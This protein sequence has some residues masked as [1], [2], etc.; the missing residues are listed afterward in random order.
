M[1]V[2]GLAPSGGQ[3]VRGR[4]PPEA[5]EVFAAESAILG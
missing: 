3:G 4:S 2:G 1:G 5:N